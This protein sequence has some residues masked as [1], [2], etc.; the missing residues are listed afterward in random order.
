MIRFARYAA[1]IC[2]VLV[3]ALSCSKESRDFPLAVNV[4]ATGS[5]S[6]DTFTD[7]KGISYRIART[8][9]GVKVAD[10]ERA[11]AVFDV[12]GKT[13]EKEY[14]MALHYLYQPLCKE[15]T[16]LSE[17][18]EEMLGTDPILVQAGWI[19]GGYVNLDFTFSYPKDSQS[20]HLIALILDDT[21]PM[22]TLRFTLRHNGYGE[23]FASEG[24]RSSFLEGTG[25]AC[26]DV[27]ALVPDDDRAIPVRITAPWYETA[28]D[29]IRTGGTIDLV[30]RGHLS[31]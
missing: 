7:D 31:R 25:F 27:S 13:G 12:L 2:M 10:M 23:G 17:A 6:G 20:S 18:T 4:T 28:G 14:S 8:D 1:A 21:Q 9:A 11:L 5:V 24:D 16:A 19:S 15:Y 29:D 22:D 30:T 3:L 26:F